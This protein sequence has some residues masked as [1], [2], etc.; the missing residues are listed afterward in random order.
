MSGA[1]L[2]DA[3]QM[4]AL[5]GDSQFTLDQIRRAIKTLGFDSDVHWQTWELFVNALSDTWDE[6]Y[7]SKKGEQ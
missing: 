7:L 6:D 3:D 5:I 2:I 1:K 4:V